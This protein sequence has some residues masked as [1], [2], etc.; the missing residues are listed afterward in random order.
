MH[1][2]SMIFEL[3]YFSETYVAYMVKA[4]VI[5][6]EVTEVNFINVTLKKIGS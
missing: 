3:H 1:N 2:S 4:A 5:Y 6:L